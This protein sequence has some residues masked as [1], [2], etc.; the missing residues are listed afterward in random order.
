MKWQSRIIEAILR[1]TQGWVVGRSL[2]IYVFCAA[3][4]PTRYEEQLSVYWSAGSPVPNVLL[5]SACH[6]EEGLV[7]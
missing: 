7:G 3:R 1:K 6:E 4:P 2:L 5:V